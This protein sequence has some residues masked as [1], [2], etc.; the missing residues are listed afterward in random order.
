[1]NFRSR[2]RDEEKRNIEVEIN[3][4]VEEI[5][6]KRMAVE[7]EKRAQEIETEVQRRLA[8]ARRAMSIEMMEELERQK[9]YELKRFLEKEVTIET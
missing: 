8:E 7:R 2:E 5:V 6:E 1:M 3:R 9:Q 4:R